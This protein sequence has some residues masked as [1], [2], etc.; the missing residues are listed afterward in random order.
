MTCSTFS[1]LNLVLNS[2]VATKDKFE[3]LL[4]PDLINDVQFPVLLITS[5]EIKEIF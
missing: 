4:L 1:A 2:F 5:I 3:F